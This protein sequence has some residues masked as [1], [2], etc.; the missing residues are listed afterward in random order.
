MHR[1]AA[2]IPGFTKSLSIH[3]HTQSGHDRPKSY[4]CKSSSNNAEILGIESAAAGM[5]MS[6]PAREKLSTT[7]M[8][9]EY[10]SWWL[11]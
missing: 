1:N 7:N 4:S 9:T 10:R 6:S 3:N 11:R 8:I 2:Q 5:C